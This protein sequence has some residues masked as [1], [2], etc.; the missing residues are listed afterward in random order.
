MVKGLSRFAEYFRDYADQYILIGGSACD[1][2]LESLGLRFRATKDLDIVLIVEAITDAF[3]NRFWGFIADGRYAPGE[4]DGKKTF[5]RF[6]KPE[7]EDFPKMIELFARKP[8]LI[9]AIPGMHLTDIPTGEEASSLSAIL[10]DDA[11]YK[12]TLAN[13]AFSENLHYA[14]TLAL[15]ALKAKAFLNNRLRKEEGQ[16]V[17]DEDVEKHKRDVIRLTATLAPEVSVDRP[18][19]IRDDLRRYVEIFREERPDLGHILK[20]QGMGNI[21]LEQITEQLIRTFNL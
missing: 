5:Y 17:R 16:A 6:V 1:W 8:D 13:S 15:I 4:V 10:M 11:Y 14:N 7:A 20:E 18:E 12:F 21:S 3:A 9:K 19:I 2:Q